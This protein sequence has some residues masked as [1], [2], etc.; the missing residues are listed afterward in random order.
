M[1]TKARKTANNLSKS[2]LV[3]NVKK[4]I[5][6]VVATGKQIQKKVETTYKQAKKEVKEAKEQ[7]KKDILALKPAKTK[8]SPPAKTYSVH[9][10]EPMTTLKDMQRV[11]GGGNRKYEGTRK[12]TAAE[13][14]LYSLFVEDFVTLVDPKATAGE[15][16]LAGLSMVPIF[17]PLKAVDAA[18]D[19]AKA[20]DKAQVI[21]NVNKSK[22]ARESSNFNKYLIKEKE[23]IENIK[24]STKKVEVKEQDSKQFTEYVKNLDK[25]TGKYTGGRI[26][27][28]LDDL[29]GDPSHGGRIKDQGI[30]E[31]EIGLDL[32]SQGKLGRILRDQKADKGAEFIDVTTG[33]KWDVKSFVS[34]PNGHTSPK[35]GAFTAEKSMRKINEEFDRGHNVIIDTRD[36]TSE[37]VDQLKKAIKDAGTSDKVIWYP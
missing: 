17:K 2:K 13:Q 14:F 29:A 11:L 8:N 28:E 9:D 31:R 33:Q 37:H 18:K 20:Y 24:N 30:K 4:E 27:K 3:K 21:E 5:K 15:K 12:A 36:L 7:F 34:Y 22:K 1:Y 35:K 32:E 25:G 10:G 19:T 6:Q 23:V 26:Q 16:T